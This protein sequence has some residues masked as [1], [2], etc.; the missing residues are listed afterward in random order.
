MKTLAVLPAR[1]ASTRFP[2]KP[3]ALIAGKPMIQWVWEAAQ[4]A[5]VDKVV[6]AT[7]DDR[8]ATAVSAFGGQVVL[9]DPALSSGTDRVAATMVALDKL[10]ERFDTVLNIQGDEPAMRS[11]TIVAVVE[12]MAQTPELP[13][14]TAACPFYHRDDIFSP[15]NVKVVVDSTNRA[16]YFSRSPIPYLRSSSCFDMDFRAWMTDE[17]LSLF[18]CHLGIYAYRPDVLRRFTSLPPH[19][20]EEAEKLEQLRALA[21]G[22]TIGVAPT[23]HPSMGVDTPEDVAR[24]KVMLENSR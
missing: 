12:L 2:G 7:D 4:K 9:T 15:N 19:P 20:L 22:I 3:L 6:V 23:L 21:A 8:I 16:L 1:F 24:V 14:A 13:M 17:Q 5:G 10:G 11:E 18:R